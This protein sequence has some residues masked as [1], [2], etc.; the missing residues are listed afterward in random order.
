M[1]STFRF[2]TLAGLCFA[3]STLAF[4]QNDPEAR[5]AIA[6]S[7][8]AVTQKR[9]VRLNLGESGQLTLGSGT[10]LDAATGAVVGT[11]SQSGT[12][13]SGLADTAI[14]VTPIPT[15]DAAFLAQGGPSNGN[16]FRFSML[17]GPPLLGRTT[18][19]PAKIS[20]I[21]LTLLNADG[22]TLMTV[23]F[24]PFETLALNSPNFRLANYASG[25]Q[26]QY[27]DAVQRA[28]FFNSMAPTWHTTLQP[29]VVN[30]VN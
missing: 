5:A 28:E 14:T 29:S 23:P 2:A 18:S 13:S 22:S 4:A 3:F 21:S 27:G 6:H 7:H 8:A 1:H 11:S 10:V 16:I 19:I 17:G 12:N 30:R 20:E 9:P 26:I 25:S 24:D 15:F